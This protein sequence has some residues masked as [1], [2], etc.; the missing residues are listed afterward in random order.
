MRTNEE[1]IEALHLRMRQRRQTKALSRSRAI[2]ISAYAA[3]LAAVILFAL[4]TAQLPA[5]NAVAPANG[6]A[7][8]I[9]AARG[10]LGYVVVAFLSFLLGA[11]VTILCGRLKKQPDDKEKLHDRDH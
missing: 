4:W 6:L 5:Q 2:R 1:R 8:G 7:A 11:L 9:F 10:V 3:C